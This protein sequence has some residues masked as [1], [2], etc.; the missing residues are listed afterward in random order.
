MYIINLIACHYTCLTCSGSANTNCSTC[1]N[2]SNYRITNPDGSG[3]CTC[4]SAYYDD[5]SNALCK[6]KKNCFIFINKKFLGMH[7]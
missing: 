1:P 4:I 7:V 3:K 6:V 2:A 5:L